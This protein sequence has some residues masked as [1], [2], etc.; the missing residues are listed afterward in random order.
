MDDA[1]LDAIREML[2]IHNNY[3]HQIQEFF[4]SLLEVVLRENC[5]M[6]QDHFERN[7]IYINPLYKQYCQL[8]HRYIDDIIRLSTGPD[9]NIIMFVAYLNTVVPTLHFTMEHDLETVNFLDVTIKKEGPR[10]ITDLYKK[11]TERNH[12]LHFS[13]FHSPSLK[14]NLPKSK[15]VRVRRIVSEQQREIQRLDKMQRRFAVREYPRELLEMARTEVESLPQNELRQ[16]RGRRESSRLA[17]VSKYTT[18]RNN[19]RKI[20]RK[21]WHILQT[22]ASHI[23]IFSSPLMAYQRGENLQDS[24]IKADMGA[25]TK[26]VRR[27]VRA[28]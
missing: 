18:A 11:E 4:L 3:P 2:I 10:L 20:I 23:Q 25:S 12:L 15:F 17:F 6:F 7:Y 22:C 13:S 28:Q 9:H 19:V 27:F 5:F 8:Y 14:N 16:Q 1:G 21:H 24:L 26:S